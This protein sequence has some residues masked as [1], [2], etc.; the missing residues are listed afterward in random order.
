M[1]APANARYAIGVV[2]HGS[3]DD[4]ALCLESVRGQS[5]AP[6]AVYVVDT[7]VDPPR[8]AALADAWPDARF[9]QRPNLG[10]GAGVNRILARVAEDDPALA[11]V[12]ILNPDVELDPDF[13]A[14][15][16]ASIE[17]DASVAIASGKLLRP[18]GAVIDSAGIRLPRHR[19]PRDR[20]SDEPDRGQYDVAQHVFAVSGAAMLVRRAALADLAVGGEIVDEDF[21]AYHDDTDLCW[22][23]NRLGWRVL[24]EPR[25]RAVHGRRWRRERRMQME[26]W[27]RRHS[28]KNHYLQIIK[29][30]RGLDLL[31]N[32]PWLLGWEVLRLGFAVLRDRSILLGYRDAMRRVPR[33]LAKRRE[34]RAQIRARVGR[35]THARA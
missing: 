16:V 14:I 24:Y 31:A 8:L 3:Y 11:H 25:A 7:G 21:F 32:L 13:A 27:V 19:R 12:L 34:I 6:A 20:G 17:A 2:N 10:W 22:R 18:G 29:N 30:E 26:P 1:R 4:L 33:A 35:G 5:A 9:E 28:F 23:A 15:L